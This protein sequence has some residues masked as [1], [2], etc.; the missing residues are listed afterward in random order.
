L[1]LPAAGGCLGR[2]LLPQG[3]QAREALL[4][5]INHE[6]EWVL[7]Q[8]C[9]FLLLLPQARQHL[10]PTGQLQQRMAVYREG[11]KEDVSMLEADSTASAVT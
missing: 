11:H 10:Q 2:L 1:L 5:C 4:L 8:C 9:C 3:L 6:V 7:L